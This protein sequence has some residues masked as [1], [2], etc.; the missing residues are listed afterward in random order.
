V[1]YGITVLPATRQK[2]CSRL[3]PSHLKL[4]LGLAIPRDTRLSWS[5]WLVTYRDC[6]LTWRWSPVPVLTG[7]NIEQLCCCDER[8]YH[9]A[10]LP[11]IVQLLA[12]HRWWVVMFLLVGWLVGWLVDWLI[13]WLISW[14]IICEV[15]RYRMAHVNKGSLNFTSHPHVHPQVYIRARYVLTD[16]VTDWPTDWW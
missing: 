12:K 10:K 13:D 1:P 11:T 5:G 15:P 2:R 4:V 6:I 16:W 3:Y 14:L 7:L 8:H 9:Y